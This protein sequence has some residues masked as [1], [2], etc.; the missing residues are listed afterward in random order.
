MVAVDLDRGN[1]VVLPNGINPTWSWDGSKI[2]FVEEGLFTSDGDGADV[3]KI[4]DDATARFPAW[5]PDGNRIA[6]ERLNLELLE[7]D[8]NDEGVN[9]FEIVV[10]NLANNSEQIIRGGK[11]PAWSPDGQKIAYTHITDVF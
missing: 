1:Q 11:W 7:D 4:S 8:P 10:L 3:K 2:A 9:P 5:S 6:F